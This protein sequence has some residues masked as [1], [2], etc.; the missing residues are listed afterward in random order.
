M[1]AIE[2]VNA[3]PEEDGLHKFREWIESPDPSILG[4]SE[5]GIN[6]KKRDSKVGNSDM[7]FSDSQAVDETQK[8]KQI[9]MDKHVRSWFPMVST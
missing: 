5:A 1:N 4:K 9:F 6:A 8:I 2:V 7:N 3:F